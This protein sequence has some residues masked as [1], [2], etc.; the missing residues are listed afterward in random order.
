MAQPLREAATDQLRLPY[1][2]LRSLRVR[3]A[4]HCIGL[5]K[6]YKDTNTFSPPSESESRLPLGLIRNT[7]RNTKIQIHILH[8]L[9]VRAAYHGKSLEL[10]LNQKEGQK[11]YKRHKYKYCTL[12]KM[13]LTDESH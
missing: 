7:K 1:C 5:D 3:A 4:Y 8:S 2:T 12:H 13:K 6:K 11:Y 9:R 10:G